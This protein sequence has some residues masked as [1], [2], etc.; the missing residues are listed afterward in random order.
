MKKGFTLL[1]LLISITIFAGI[2]VIALGAFA[3][4]ATTAAKSNDSRSK[5][6]AARSFIDQIS[7][8]FRFIDTTVTLPFD[9][10]HCST[11]PTPPVGATWKGFCLDPLADGS[12]SVFLLLKYPGDS[13]YTGKL[14][15]ASTNSGDHDLW[16]AE[17]RNCSVATECFPVTADA[18]SVLGS[19][20]T[21]SNATV[22]TGQ[23]DTASSSGYLGVRLVLRSHD[24]SSCTNEGSCYELA[25]TLTSGGF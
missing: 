10:D 18:T 13:T 2:M 16:V 17:K 7:N 1:E 22:F 9:S 8:D 25:T 19:L 12:N 4:S 15:Y 3:R 6:E 20:Y 11:K 23:A 14:Y 5:T 24:A 21:A